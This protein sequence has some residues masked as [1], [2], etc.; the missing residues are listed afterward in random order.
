MSDRRIRLAG[1]S[2]ILV[3]C[4]C[5]D[6]T[7]VIRCGD[8]SRSVEDIVAE[9]RRSKYHEL[10]NSPGE[11]V[12]AVIRNSVVRHVLAGPEPTA[13]E[14]R[15]LQAIG[16]ARA[17][18]ECVA[19]G[20]KRMLAK[21][22]DLDQL[23]R[24]RFEAD[25]DAF[26][27]PESFRLQMIF[28]PSETPGARRLARR[29]LD[30]VRSDPN[31]FEEL[32]RRHSRSKTA[33]TGGFAGPMPGS[34]VHP[35][36]R[37][38]LDKHRDSKDPFL[39]EIDRGFYVLRI[40]DYWPPVGG[41]YEENAAAVRNRVGAKLLEEASQRISLE[42]GGDHAIVVDDT[43]F[44]EP[45]VGRSRTVMTIDGTPVTA[46]DILPAMSD[47][48]TVVGPTLRTE[49]EAYR[50]TFLAA[51]YF[52]CPRAEPGEITP[53]RLAALRVGDALLSQTLEQMDGALESY[54]ELHRNV[55]RTDPAWRF[56]L[57]V[58]PRTGDDPY[59]D[60][61]R[62]TPVIDALERGESPDPET[63]EAAGALVF[64][65]LDLE[66]NRI[67]RYEPR[68]LQALEQL[69][70]GETSGPIR[71][72]R[73]HAFLVVRREAVTEARPLSLSNPEDRRVIAR[74][75]IADNRDE[76]MDAFFEAAAANCRINKKLIEQC[77]ARL[78]ARPAEESRRE[79]PS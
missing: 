22:G 73:L 19:L 56:D 78:S 75:F 14:L 10:R 67:L 36:M 28:I 27:L 26:T 53:E 11:L 3:L 47:G 33:A 69:E 49:A 30:E 31:V 23:A 43:V 51:T 48:D 58:F 44:F 32:A 45:V 41:T 20:L 8:E 64:P 38:A 39:V 61:H 68:I 24:E 5:G 17:R 16:R 66:E 37:E 52:D 21:R 7:T 60:L 65:G 59:R 54:F 29:L 55:L 13:D 18:Q 72:T 4:A 76:V 62:N 1:V 79:D 40:L 34:A 77:V 35:A 2:L 57:W 12:D 15:R 70:N 63:V 42:I 74:S 50:R 6:R 25:P 9:A 71:S 46:G